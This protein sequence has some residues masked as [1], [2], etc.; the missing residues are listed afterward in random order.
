M[1]IE[2]IKSDGQENTFRKFFLWVSFFVVF[3]TR[4][5]NVSEKY[6]IIREK[7]FSELTDKL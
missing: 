3:F 6:L 7:H 5:R 1:K 4:S 2:E